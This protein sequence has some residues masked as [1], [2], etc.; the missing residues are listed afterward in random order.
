MRKSCLF[1]L[2]FL[3]LTVLSA[4]AVAEPLPGDINGDGR[5]DAVDIQLVI[6]EVLG[7]DTGLPPGVADVDGDGV[8]NAQDIQLVISMVLGVFEP[9]EAR[10]EAD[11]VSG[12]APL[13]VQFEDLSDGGT[14]SITD[15]HWDFGDGA[16]S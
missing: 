10:F 7:I 11:P 3:C 6:I 12:M 15:W 13:E 5:T 16:T 9:P 2:L 1:P 14:D 4:S 8:V